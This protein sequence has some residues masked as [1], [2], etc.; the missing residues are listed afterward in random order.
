MTAQDYM[1]MQEAITARATALIQQA[2]K[3]ENVQERFAAW[4]AY[5][6]ARAEARD[7]AR[8][9]S[10]GWLKDKGDARCQTTREP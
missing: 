3:A 6:A 10:L 8:A 7:L 9:W 4:Q 2:F 5:K 1:D